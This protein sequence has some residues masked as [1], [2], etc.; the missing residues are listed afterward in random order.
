[1]EDKFDV[2]I[3][4]EHDGKYR[5]STTTNGYQ[6][7]GLGILVND[8]KRAEQIAEFLKKHLAEDAAINRKKDVG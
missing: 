6:W 7:W 8:R 4:E 3:E 5:I 2:C 1:M